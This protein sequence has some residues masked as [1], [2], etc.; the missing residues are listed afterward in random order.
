MKY[1][2]CV[3]SQEHAL[4]GIDGGFIQVCHGKKSPLARMKK[5]DYVTFYCPN[6]T[7][8]G[9]DK[10]Q[11][12]VGV[13]QVKDGIVYQ[14]SMSETFHP[15]RMDIAYLENSENY[16]TSILPL[17]EKLQFI[18]NKKHWGYIFRY[19]HLAIELPDF[20]VILVAMGVKDL[21]LIE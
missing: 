12:F 17:I 16:S 18:K 8:Q 2:I 5:G 3:V 7:F 14:Y 13:G 9:K 11:N 19:G 6:I 21:L 20:K 15:Y 10:C 4:R 1:W